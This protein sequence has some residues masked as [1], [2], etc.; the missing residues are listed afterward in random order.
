MGITNLNVLSI[1]KEFQTGLHQK[2]LYINEKTFFV[3]MSI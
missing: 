3:I 2:P 1:I